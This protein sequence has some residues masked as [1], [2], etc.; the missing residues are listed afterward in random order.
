MAIAVGDASVGCVQGSHPGSPCTGLGETAGLLLPQDPGSRL[1]RQ[2]P[3][4][5]PFMMLLSRV[6]GSKYLAL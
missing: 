3:R 5:H 2:W 4:V 1:Q 6:M